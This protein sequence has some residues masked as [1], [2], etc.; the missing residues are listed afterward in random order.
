MTCADAAFAGNTL[1]TLTNFGGLLGA[2]NQGGG[3]IKVR[4]VTIGAIA[5]SGAPGRRQGCC[6][7]YRRFGQGRRQI[8]VTDPARL[9]PRESLKPSYREVDACDRC[10]QV[11]TV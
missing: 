10:C 2:W 6:L 7:R 8:E 5:V 4:N 11:A 9:I 1:A 3:P